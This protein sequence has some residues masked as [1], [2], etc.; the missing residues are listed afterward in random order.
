M[1]NYIYI[2]LP[3]IYKYSP[4]LKRQGKEKREKREKYRGF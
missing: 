4:A 1:Y 3:P 2:Y